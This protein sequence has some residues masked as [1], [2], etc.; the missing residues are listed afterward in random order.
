[1][2]L[3]ELT[4]AQVSGGH[5]KISYLLVKGATGHLLF[6]WNIFPFNSINGVIILFEFVGGI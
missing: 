1:M 4:P 6:V 5:P 3:P 2:L